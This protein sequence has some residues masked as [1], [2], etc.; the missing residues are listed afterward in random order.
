MSVST[1]KFHPAPSSHARTH[2][3]ERFSSSDELE[4]RLKQVVRGEVRFDNGAR[5]LYATDS[6]NYR[7][8]PIGLVVPRDEADVEATLRACRE[9]GAPVLPRGGGTSLAGQCCNVAV[10]IDFSK[11]M[12]ELLRLDP[13][14]R[15]ARVRPGIVLDRLRDAAEKH[16]LTFAPD[17]A[18]HSRCTLGGMIG[19]NSCG[20][21]ALMGGKT[22]DN[23]HALTV[24]L[25][26]GT[27]MTVGKTS[28]TDLEQIIAAG[29][30][31]GQIYAG[32]RQIRDQYAEAIRRK[33][34]RIPRRVSGYNLDEL[35]PENGFHVARA[36]VG[37]EGTCVTVLEAEL[38]LTASPPFRRLVAVGYHD[39]FVAADAVPGILAHKPIGLEGF[40]GQ[41]VDSMRAKG[42]RL[43]ELKLLPAGRGTLLVEFGA[44][45]SE[46]AD[47]QADQFGRWLE[48]QDP[49]PGHRICTASEAA[50]VW[51]VRES[52]LGAVAVQPG[53]Q[54]GWEGWEDAA[55]PPD[56]L[57]SYLRALFALMREYGY[58]SPL[59]GHYG[60]GCVHMRINFDLESEP[61]ILKFREFIDRAADLVIGHGGSLSGEHGDGQ[62]RGALLPKMFGPELMEAFG[63]FKRLWGPA[64]RMN[65]GKLIDARQPHQDLRL[66]A[67]YRPQQPKTHFRFP[68][69]EGS[70]ASAT[71]RCVGVGAC[72]K[73][74]GGVMCPSYM[75]TREEKHSTRGRAHLLWELLQGEVLEHGW[76]NEDVKEALDLCLSCKACKTECPT[77]VDLATY[78]AEFL[79]HYYE[80][81]RRPLHAYAFGLIDRWA[82]AASL[83][84]RLANALGRSPLTRSIA[85]TL[86][87]LP[88]ERT[89]PEF[90]STTF[91]SRVK[92]RRAASGRSGAATGSTRE[93]LL[94]A[95]TFTNYFQPQVA[96]AAFDVL[97]SAGFRVRVLD[98]HVC[99]GRPLYDFGMLDLAK[100]YLNDCMD[101]LAEELATATPI[102]VL[103]P[104]CASV[105]RDELSNLLPD[106]PRSAKLKQQVLLLSECLLRHAPDYKPAQ[107]DPLES[108]CRHASL[109]I[110]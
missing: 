16:H 78:K 36:L 23:V 55:V 79:S 37:S 18:T 17:P 25:Y 8:I 45:A 75:A 98:R 68:D 34:P 58:D 102:V 106:D 92:G 57:G 73:T 50:Q 10:V 15:T 29:G 109:S 76:R 83:A 56:R 14:A 54:H 90:A 6:S 81:R 5:A 24:M 72:R 63:Q 100:R 94:W 59:Y 87:H 1:L 64:N 2:A 69:D 51:I 43:D 3:R 47:A 104:S 26:D 40:D 7:Q 96:D 99:C 70:L 21:H 11:Y 97:T 9:L 30:R 32:L 101:A 82:R 65:P 49:R 84:P 22:V 62:S 44:S 46:D 89:L 20:V 67:D 85:N 74:E 27:K 4:R 66:G 107:W 91:R 13:G 28:D 52:A 93:V 60:D 103:E 53:K 48:T 33:F 77:N 41:V 110:L 80:G 39:A 88:P 19:N 105:F 86:L 42:M 35:L 12:T 95:D 61:G 108:T 38:R 71:L 31:R